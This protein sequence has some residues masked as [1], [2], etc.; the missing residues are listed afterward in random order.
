M[1]N[2]I[3][4]G[5]QLPAFSFGTRSDVC[6]ECRR[7]AVD[8]PNSWS[9]AT[10][11]APP[12]QPRTISRRLPLVTSIIVGMN[13]AVFVA[14]VLSGVSPVEP[15]IAQLLKWGANYG[16]LTLQGQPWRLLTA[17]YVHIGIIHIALNMWCL[18]NLGFLAERI[19]GGWTYFLIYTICGIAGSLASTLVS[20]WLHPNVVG[21][22]ASG[23][24]FGI[25][26]ALIAALYLGKLPIPKEALRGTMKSLL[27]FAAYNL[28]FGG[29]VRGI[30]NS[31]HIGGLV[32]GLIVGAGL[33]RHLVSPPDVK[34]NWTRG[35]FLASAIVLLVAYMLLKRTVS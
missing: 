19:F 26:G 20:I 31:A 21:A 16:P 34:E 9:S 6:P 7:T 17:N 32:A 30:D 25:A 18:W 2:C 28:F 33:A 12:P 4:C 13:V 5:R 24:I 10:N 8:V 15:A 1:A 22:G 11:P 14:M 29:V 23:A 27:T 3:A 35:V